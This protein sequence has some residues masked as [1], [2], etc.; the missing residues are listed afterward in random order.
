M[1][2]VPRL[3]MRSEARHRR[4]KVWPDSQYKDSR[5][6]GNKQPALHPLHTQMELRN[7]VPTLET[8]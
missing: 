3:V 8:T 7:R 6:F 2:Q 1:Q 5:I 4:R